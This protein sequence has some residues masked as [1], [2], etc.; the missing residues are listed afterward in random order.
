[1]FE[2]IDAIDHNAWHFGEFAILRQVMGLWP[3]G[4][5]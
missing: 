3:A 1:L 5:E 2:I 4:R